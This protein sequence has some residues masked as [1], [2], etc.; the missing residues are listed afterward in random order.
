LGVVLRANEALEVLGLDDGATAATIKEAYRDLVKVWHPDRFGS[1]ARLREKAEEKLKEI[2]LAYQTLLRGEGVADPNPSAARDVVPGPVEARAAEV[3]S[4][5]A[6]ARREMFS[7]WW[8]YVAVA[9]LVAGFVAYAVHSSRSLQEGPV[10]ATQPLDAPPEVAA[11]KPPDKSS[12]ATAPARFAVRSLT[13]AQ[14]AKVEAECAALRDP[15]AHANCVRAQLD[16]VMNREGAP[17]LAGLSAAERESIESA[18]AERYRGSRY[19]SCL[20]AQMAEWAA[21]PARVD[22]S[23]VS[24]ADRVSIESACAGAKRR[25]PAAYDRC[26]LRLVTALAEAK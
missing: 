22:L 2:N 20:T 18:C 1:D 15:A 21:E 8:L 10:T 25:G 3:R 11:P 17:S 13:D 5:P 19:N 26:R 4:A 6:A 7:P 24:E 23:G 9:M 14:T 12:G 16:A